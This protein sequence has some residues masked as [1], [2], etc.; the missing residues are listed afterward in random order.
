[1]LSHVSHSV[2]TDARGKKK[3]EKREG[4]FSFPVGAYANLVFM[5][6]CQCDLYV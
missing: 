2:F 3:R 5:Q 6:M 4:T 1:M